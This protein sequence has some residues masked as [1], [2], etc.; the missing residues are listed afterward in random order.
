MT[1]HA[2]PAGPNKS[3]GQF[4]SDSSSA[5]SKI[6]LDNGSDNDST[7]DPEDSD[8]SSDNDEQD[9][10]SVINKGE[11]PIEHYGAQAESLDISQLWQKWYSNTT[12]EK[13]DETCVY[14]DMCH[15]T[16]LDDE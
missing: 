15:G 2:Q 4:E 16:Q 14:W 7:S 9:E 6:F 12:Q 5:V 10:E 1:P 3:E 13:L 11:L 8:E